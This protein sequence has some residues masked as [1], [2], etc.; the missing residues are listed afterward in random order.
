M[1]AAFWHERWARN[2]IAWHEKTA[3]PLLDRHF[4]RLRLPVGARVFVPLCGKTRD[5][6]WLLQAGFRVAGVELSRLA[7]DQLFA[8]L[9]VTPV[10]TDHGPLLRYSAEGLDVFVG[11][12][13]ELSPALL[14]P[15][16]ATYD[17]AALVALPPAL[18]ERYAARLQALTA[19]APQLLIC[20]DYEQHRMAG[21]PHAVPAAEVFR[22][23]GHHY[24]LT[25]LD[26]LTVAGGLKGQCEATE[27]VWWLGGRSTG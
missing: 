26:V 4:H 3:H 18:R 16:A 23:Y 10:I 20:F 14:G 13:F 25:L 7:I 19:Q 27:Q 22:H 17:R 11:D 8:E 5:I 6:A 1:E 9:G 12:L 24:T 21:P 2:E 15:V